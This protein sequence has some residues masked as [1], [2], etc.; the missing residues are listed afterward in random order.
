[1]RIMRYFIAEKHEKDI[2]N[3]H[4]VLVTSLFPNITPVNHS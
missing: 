1:M 2:R 4:N 3:L